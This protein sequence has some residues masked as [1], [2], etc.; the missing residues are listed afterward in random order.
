MER[1]SF[2]PLV[3]VR[4]IMAQDLGVHQSVLGKRAT[5]RSQQGELLRDTPD[6]AAAKVWSL[7]VGNL[8]SSATK[9]ILNAACDTLPHNSNLSLW[10][11][12]VPS[13]CPLC[14]QK[15]TLLH[16]L[17]HCPVALELMRFNHRHDAVLIVIS[18]LV[19]A[20]L[21]PSQEMIADLPGSTYQYPQHISCTDARPDIVVW[22]DISKNVYL[23]ELTVC[24][25]TNFEVARE[26]KVSR[27][28]DLVEEAEQ[29][30]YKCELEVGSRDV[31]E[32]EWMD[33]LKRL[34]DVARR[35]WD[36]FLVILAE[37]A[38][39][40]SHKIWNVRKWKGRTNP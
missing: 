36:T 18:E 27:Y 23:I 11:R 5:Q 1:I 6:Q 31:V 7:A 15:Q 28:T 2:R 34:M 10:G 35:E 39:K 17:N 26:R 16:I 25:E 24:F 37:T 8:S 19:R 14:G 32:V 40:E 3:L 22:D 4:D 9:F 21:T 20:N 33:R 29:H 12:G 30:G 38:M 13:G